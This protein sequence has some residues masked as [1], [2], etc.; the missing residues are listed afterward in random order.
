MEDNKEFAHLDA[1]FRRA[2]EDLPDT[3]SPSGWDTPSPRVW[4]G[5]RTHLKTP[6]RSGG[7]AYVALLI[8]TASAALLFGLYWAFLK[9]AKSPEAPGAANAVPYEVPTAIVE[10]APAAE[11]APP[12]RIISSTP[13]RAPKP[14][15]AA[16]DVHRHAEPLLPSSAPLPGSVP[17]PNTTIRREVEA[18]RNA[19][20]AQPLQPLP[21]RTSIQHG[22]YPPSIRQWLML[23]AP[24]PE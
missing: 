20:W 7:G 8:A 2:F 10:T 3:P 21:L 17:A 18:L 4:E 14:R 24:K 13:A 11:T 6:P 22:T 23:K 19:P 9:P 12:E 16:F 15:N 1:L 5:V